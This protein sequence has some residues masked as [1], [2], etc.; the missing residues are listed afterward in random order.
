M[1]LFAFELKENTEPVDLTRLTYVQLYFSDEEKREF[2]TLCK[3]GM[4]QYYGQRAKDTN[5]VDFLLDVLR[6]NFGEQKTI[7]FES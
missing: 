3:K 5:A 1:E 6:R 2:N 4:I 7:N